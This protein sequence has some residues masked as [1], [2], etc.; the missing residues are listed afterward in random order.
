MKIDIVVLDYSRG[1]VTVFRKCELENPSEDRDENEIVEDFLDSK[2]FHLSN[3]NWM[4]SEEEI[5]L[6]IR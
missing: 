5:E 6:E 4:Y 3:C 1:T 2:G